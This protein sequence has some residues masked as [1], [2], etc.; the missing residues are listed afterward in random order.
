MLDQ[1][2]VAIVDDHLA[3]E[4][5][6]GLQRFS[7]GNPQVQSGTNRGRE[8]GD[9]EQIRDGD[10]C[11]IGRDDPRDPEAQRDQQQRSAQAHAPFE[12]QI[13]GQAGKAAC[14][15]N[16]APPGPQGNVEG[17]SDGQQYN[18]DGTR[19]IEIA[20]NQVAEQQQKQARRDARFPGVAVKCSIGCDLLRTG[21]LLRHHLCRD[22]LEGQRDRRDEDEEGVDRRGMAKAGGPEKSRHRNVIEKVD[23]GDQ[24]R[25]RQQHETAGKHPGLGSPRFAIQGFSVRTIDHSHGLRFAP[26]SQCSGQGANRPAQPHSSANHL[27]MRK[28]E[29]GAAA[30]APN[31]GPG[32]RLPAT[33]GP[34]SLSKRSG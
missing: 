26:V 19:Q 24:S 9:H 20:G 10:R 25:T 30:G 27:L 7:E 13:G 2:D 15:L 1:Y 17:G 29:G 12:H 11:G 6:D 22:N 18:Q 16:V 33:A 23:G 4:E 21:P 32:P 3:H 34:Y 31:G 8:R 5:N 14:P 28:A